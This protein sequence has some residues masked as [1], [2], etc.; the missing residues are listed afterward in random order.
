MTSLPAAFSPLSSV[1]SLTFA[2]SASGRPVG[3]YLRPGFSAGALLRMKL[4]R[5][6]FLWVSCVLLCLCANAL[7]TSLPSGQ[8]VT[9][10]VGSPGASIIYTFTSTAGNVVDFTMATTSG[11]LNPKIQLYSPSNALLQTA[12]PG[13]CEGSTVEMNAVLLAAAGTYTVLISDCS[14][15]NMGNY[16]LTLQSV[17]SPSGASNLPF[18][19]TEAG[20]IA[21]ATQ[22]NTYTFSAS[23]GDVIDFTLAATGNLNPRIRIYNQAGGALVGSANP[24]FCEGSTVELDTLHI[25]ATG[26]YTVLFGDCSD[27]NSGSY[28]IYVQKTDGPPG[29]VIPLGQVQTGSITTAAQ[30]NTFSI[31]ANANDVFDF[32]MLTTKGNLNPRFR[33][34]SDQTGALLKDVSPGF[35]EGST[36]EL[37]GFKFPT[38]GVY[39]VLLGDCSDTNTGTY[40]LYAQRVNN[41][42][43]VVAPLPFSQTPTGLVAAAAQSNTY[44]FSANANDLIDFTMAATSGSLNP[45]IRIY[46]QLDG[47]L[48]GSANPG[49][50][51]GTTIEINTLK[52]PTTGAYTVLVADCS[53]AN[54]GNY[55]VY[56]QRTN[57]PSP[58]SSSLIWGGSTQAG[59][60]TAGAQNNTYVFYVPSTATI[61]NLNMVTTKGSLNPRI[62]LYNPDGSLNNTVNPGFC[63]GST[64][65][66]SSIS[67]TKPGTYTV[68]AGDCSDTNTGN[69]NL[70]GQCIGCQVISTITWPAPAAIAYPTPLSATQLDASASVGTT[71]LTGSYAYTYTSSKGATGTAAIGTVLGAGSYTLSVQFTPTDNSDYAPA[72]ATVPLTVTQG[73]PPITW[74]TPAAITYGTAIGP[75]QLD[76]STAVSGAFVFSPTAGTVLAAGSQKL[77]AT[78]TPTDTADYLTA[79]PSVQLQVNQ[80]TPL[81]AWP[82]PAAITNTTPLSATQLDA[83]C[84]WTVGGTNAAVIGAYAYSYVGTGGTTGSGTATVGTALPA[85]TY[86]LSFLF[87]PADAKDYTTATGSVSLTVKS[88][89][90]ITPTVIWPAPAAITYPTALSA[91]Q[92]DATATNNGVT[93]PGT[94]AYSYA[95]T[96]GT[97]GSGTAAIGTLLKAGSWTLSVQFTPTDTKTYQAPPSKSVSLTVNQATPVLTWPALAAI[98]YGT[99]LSGAQLDATAALNGTTVPGAF[100]YT[101]TSTGAS[102]AATAGT[103]LKAGSYT[104]GVTFTPTDSADYA[105]VKG[106]DSFTVNQATPACTW[107][108]PAAIT[109]PT[110]LSASQLNAACSWTVGGVAGPVAGVYAYSYTGT[111][112]SGA[113]T[114][115]TILAPGTYTLGFTL[116]PADATDYLKA[117]GSVPLTVNQ[118]VAATP[119][120]SV[121]AGTYGA[122]QLVTLT[123]TTPGAT[124]YW[125]TTG[126]GANTELTLYTGPIMVSLSQTVSAVA[127]APGYQES[128]IA[129][130]AY[131]IAGTASVLAAPPTAIGTTT[132][133]L[134]AIVSRSGLPG[135]YVF[136]Y[137]TSSTAL[138]L[139][140]P[141]T[142]FAATTDP[143]VISATISGLTTKTKYY[144]QVVVTT[145]A[146]VATGAMLNFTTN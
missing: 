72:K 103:V 118:P 15:T 143:V 48:V 83:S 98:T 144:Y 74:A 49:F 119:V 52:I 82:A 93:V 2:A 132:A 45:R 106:S 85:G 133:T 112:G 138:T 123:D 125:S 31:S 40:S 8:T 111:G 129:T 130:A 54:T 6:R 38:A 10:S 139:S 27:T 136:Q 140:T 105:T 64:I 104:L 65:T 42:G 9:G 29:P 32:T 18:G 78:F 127:L 86:T 69:Y 141:A 47:S 114:V 66:M 55:A 79:N 25:S 121:A 46:N 76:P 35:C 28:E 145:P 5:S 4:L 135:T 41:P 36:I 91:T 109:N 33:L 39:T 62:R 21:S 37:N 22:N 23:A 12:A 51:E 97:T 61:L 71:A 89:T 107:P 92:L 13:F 131:V 14:N 75:T 128:A 126:R 122:V 60:L 63:E 44:T 101:Y 57:N 80:A 142:A 146:G 70:S 96:G 81:C 20:T 90:I 110:P 102:G 77:S 117:A 113:A 73:V 99:A 26:T 100:A 68:L 124:L 1:C 134:S 95:G 7:A 88:S 94:F 34:Y 137:G 16:A 59:T 19:Q 17:T 84:N 58:P 24:G 43:G 87:T 3:T 30:S 67:L 50:C 53:D 11:N 56:T 108:S 120:F 116:N 115:G